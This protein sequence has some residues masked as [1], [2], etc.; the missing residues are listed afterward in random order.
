MNGIENYIGF[1]IAGVILNLTP[2]ADSIYI[3]TRSVAQGRK[4]G[5]Y[6]ILGIGTGALL[7]T[8][9]AAFGL[10]MILMKSAMIFNI[11]KYVGVAYLVY[12][13]IKMILDKSPMFENGKNKFENPDLFK[14]FKQ[15]FFTNLLNPKVAIFFLSLMPQFI[16]P[17]Y[18]EGP[19]PFLI[20]GFTFIT[21]GTIWCLFL[22]YSASSMTNVLRKND[23][24]GKIM[25][26]I[27]GG[28]FIAL[29]LQILLKRTN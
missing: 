18:V 6:S 24:V 3:I 9:F 5:I 17:E 1:L 14:I 8:F 2:G 23:K 4:A 7:H 22:A 28:I 26:K 29:G 16:K 25:Q 13:G 27:S 11:I 10:S 19:I 12:L 20:L 15:G 21:T